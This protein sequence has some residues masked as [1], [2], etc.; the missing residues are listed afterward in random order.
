MLVRI[1]KLSVFYNQPPLVIVKSQYNESL[2]CR[3]DP[4]IANGVFT[5]VIVQRMEK[6][7][8]LTNPRYDEGGI[9]TRDWKPRKRSI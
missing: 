8:N 1:Q 3:E 5:P 7:S 4:G 9:A 2:Y 6:N